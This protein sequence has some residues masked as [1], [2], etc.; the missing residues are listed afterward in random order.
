MPATRAP[1]HEF[2][3]AATERDSPGRRRIRPGTVRRVIP[4]IKKYRWSLVLLITLTVIDAGVTTA[5]PLLFGVIIDS[6]IVPRHL[7]V[8]IELTVLLAGLAIADA[9]AVYIQTRISARIGQGLVYDLRTEVFEHVQKQTPV[10]FTR[11]QTGSLVSRLNSDVV[12]A[13][14]AVTTLLSRTVD[15]LLTLVFVLVAMFY[16]SWQISL[17]AIVIVPVLV[18]P[19]KAVGRRLQRLT[20]EQMQLNAEL[21]SVMNERF[22]VA[23]SILVRLFGRPDE[24]ARLFA[25]KAGRVRDVGARANVM[26]QVLGIAMSLSSSLILALTFGIGGYLVIDHSFKIGTLVALITLIGRIYGPINQLSGIQA[27]ILTSLVSF[28]RLFEVLDLK[29]LVTQRPAATALPAGDARGGDTGDRDTGDGD[30]GRRDTCVG[31]APE[32]EFDHVSFS[33]PSADAVSLVSL[34]SVRRPVHESSGEAPV[35]SDVSFRVPAGRLTALVGPS[36][37]GKT[38]LTQMVPRFYDP[39]SGE[40]RISGRDIRDLTL[41]SVQD[42][43]G[44]VTQD[45]HLFHDTIRQN[46]LYARPDASESDLVEACEAAQIWPLIASLPDGLDTVAGDRG[47]RL[48]GGEKQRIALARLLLKAPPIV[49]L[50]EATAHLDVESEAAVQRALRTALSGRT[51]LVIAHRLTTIRA[52]DQIVVI[53]AGRIRQRGTHEELLMEEGLYASLY[54]TQFASQGSN[55]RGE[56]AGTGPL[57]G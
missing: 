15:T 38:T 41:R 16:L 20:R 51:S 47:F 44:M 26:G 2:G 57:P 1:A 19:G 7:S 6:G 27:N 50:D 43:V 54:R 8:V 12:G 17:F 14:Q 13:Q 34:E 37:A 40:V 3:T 42:T 36:G 25:D 32:I 55:G 56:T 39:D 23:G 4:Y 49:V 33:Y 28:D 35:L 5:N 48:S 18:L 53:D 10:F 21:A 31:R 11:S 29:P 22:N 46:L 45:A 52:A 30:T 9:C 24:E